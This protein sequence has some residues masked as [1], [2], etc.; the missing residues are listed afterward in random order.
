[1]WKVFFA[2]VLLLVSSI[3]TGCVGSTGGLQ[4]Y[5]NA[6]GGYQ[7]L[8][9]N[10]WTRV[11][12]KKSAGVD[13]VFHDIIE[14]TENVSVIINPVTDNKTLADLGTPTEVGYRL[15]KNHSLNPALDKEVDLIRAESRQQNGQ[16]YYLLEYQ[17]KFPDD[18]ERH[19]LASVTARNGKLYSFNLSTSQKRWAKVHELFETIVDSFSVT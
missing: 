13:V 4:S 17:V 16:E 1:M 9:P 3:V 12:V 18:R 2:L 11:E 19:N 8:Y 6:K 10:G 5:V 7:F 14:T 15:L